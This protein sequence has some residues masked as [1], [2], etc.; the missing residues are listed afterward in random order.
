MGQT[1][2]KTPAY[3]P[4]SVGSHNFPNH[5]SDHADGSRPYPTSASGWIK[6]PRSRFTGGR[7][8]S[9]SST[10]IISYPHHQFI[11]KE[12]RQ[13]SAGPIRSRPEPS[14]YGPRPVPFPPPSSTLQPRELPL[15]DAKL[16]APDLLVASKSAAPSEMAEAKS[17]RRTSAHRVSATPRDPP[18]L[19][20]PE[21]VKDHASA[22]GH[23]E[24]PATP[25]VSDH[26]HAPIPISPSLA[27]A[28]KTGLG[29]GSLRRRPDGELVVDDQQTGRLAT[30]EADQDA[31]ASRPGPQMENAA[32][33]WTHPPR[34]SIP[35][36]W[37]SEWEDL[38]HRP[39]VDTPQSSSFAPADRAQVSRFSFG[40]SDPT[41]TSSGTQS[42]GEL[43]ARTSSW[44]ASPRDS[45]RFSYTASDSGESNQ[46]RNSISVL[47]NPVSDSSRSGPNAQLSL[48]SNEARLALPPAAASAEST[49]R[50]HRHASRTP[51]HERSN[52]SLFSAAAASSDCDPTL[53]RDRRENGDGPLDNVEGQS[54]ARTGPT[55]SAVVHRAFDRYEEPAPNTLAASRRSSMLR[56]VYS[57]A[58]ASGH[59]SLGTKEVEQLRRGPEVKMHEDTIGSIFEDEPA[60]TPRRPRALSLMN[61]LRGMAGKT[62][63]ASIAEA[64]TVTV[65]AQPGAMASN[66]ASMRSRLRSLSSAQAIERNASDKG[67]ASPTR[68]RL[69]SQSQSQS[70]V[71][72]PAPSP[73]PRS[74]SL[75]SA[76]V[77]GQSA[78]QAASQSSQT[79]TSASSQPGG[80]ERKNAALSTGQASSETVHPP[81]SISVRSVRTQRS[82]RSA[83]SFTSSNGSLRARYRTAQPSSVGLSH[84]QAKGGSYLAPTSWWKQN[85]LKRKGS[86]GLVAE[87]QAAKQGRP[88]I[89][90]GG[91]ISDEAGWVDLEPETPASVD[92]T[93]GA[94][95]TPSSDPPATVKTSKSKV[96][97]GL[98]L[99]PRRPSAARMFSFG[100]SRSQSAQAERVEIEPSSPPRTAQT[101]AASAPRSPVNVI[102]MAMDPS[103]GTSRPGMGGPDTGNSSQSSFTS[104]APPVPPAPVP[105]LRRPRRPSQKMHAMQRQDR[106]DSADSNATLS[107]VDV[108][109]GS[110][111]LPSQQPTLTSEASLARSD[112]MRSSIPGTVPS[113]VGTSLAME[114][115]STVAT[116]VSASTQ[117]MHSS[118]SASKETENAL[119]PMSGSREFTLSPAPPM[120]R[121]LSEISDAGTKEILLSD[122]ESLA[123]PEMSP[124]TFIQGPIDEQHP[125]LQTFYPAGTSLTRPVR[126][127]LSAILSPLSPMTEEETGP[128]SP[129]HVGAVPDLSLRPTS[130]SLE[131]SLVSAIAPHGQPHGLIDTSRSFRSVRSFRST[132]DGSVHRY[133]PLPSIPGRSRGWSLDPT[134]DRRD[135]SYV[136]DSFV[137]A[138]AHSQYGSVEQPRDRRIDG[139]PMHDTQLSPLMLMGMVTA[140]SSPTHWTSSS[141]EQPMANIERAGRGPSRSSTGSVT[142]P[143]G[144]PRPLPT[145]PS[146]S[147]DAAVES[148]SAR[149]AGQRIPAVLTA[150]GGEG[151]PLSPSAFYDSKAQTLQL[152]VR[153]P[154]GPRESWNSADG[155]WS[156]AVITSGSM[157]GAVR[158]MAQPER[159]VNDNDVLRHALSQPQE[160]SYRAMEAQP[161]AG[162]EEDEDAE[163]TRLEK[164][165]SGIKSSPPS[166]RV[167]SVE[168]PDSIERAP[169]ADTGVQA[170]LAALRAL[171]S[172]GESLRTILARQRMLGELDASVTE[173]LRESRILDSE[174][175]LDDEEVLAM[176]GPRHRRRAAP[177]PSRRDLYYS[178]EELSSSGRS[179]SG[180]RAEVARRRRRG[181]FT[182]MAEASSASLP[183]TSG[184]GSD[185]EG[186]TLATGRLHRDVPIGRA[187]AH[188][189]RDRRQSVA[190][191]GAVSNVPPAASHLKAWEDLAGIAPMQ[192]EPQAESSQFDR[193]RSSVG[194]SKDI[195]DLAV[196]PP[197]GNGLEEAPLRRPRHDRY[198]TAFSQPEEGPTSVDHGPQHLDGEAGSFHALHRS[199]EPFEEVTL[200]PLAT[201]TSPASTMSPALLLKHERLASQIPSSTAMGG[202]RIVFPSSEGARGSLL[203]KQRTARSPSLPQAF[204]MAG[205]RSSHGFDTPETG[206]VI[207]TGGPSAHQIGR[208]PLAHDRQR[209]RSDFHVS[210]A[211]HSKVGPSRSERR[212]YVASRYDAQLEDLLLLRDKVLRAGSAGGHGRYDS[213]STSFDHAGTASL[214]GDHTHRID[215]AGDRP[216]KSSTSSKRK[217]RSSKLG[218]TMPDIMAWQAGLGASSNVSSR[219]A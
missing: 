85:H 203:S 58:A 14:E 63:E 45:Q 155:P 119:A 36:G 109:T 40:S 92:D 7:R 10:S 39:S 64:N 191:G 172:P 187:S 80:S 8:D 162:L 81:R 124:E 95:K 212:D 33:L 140:A 169:Y 72:S 160:D 83:K 105:P 54:S 20:E 55:L 163:L 16:H 1:P 129:R 199:A 15:T 145:I 18:L 166:Q 111:A 210:S 9:V 197:I 26:G 113:T 153:S 98:W 49:R 89:A 137:T 71:R 182:G 136:A 44:Y 21:S 148:I 151:P 97:G 102:G 115:S 88:G 38:R 79:V 69:R 68:S 164:S 190:G 180:R 158:G 133:R 177:Y 194:R 93:S 66:A 50:E 47:R 146:R 152:P 73:P 214:K 51:S 65:Q 96:A 216:R 120:S 99:W 84:S 59:S 142:S 170:S 173:F 17:I 204:A 207:S 48:T 143:V 37:Q 132:S 107:W 135:A 82:V 202:S 25:S 76:I 117:A 131:G 193:A 67:V 27:L 2:S 219:V 213:H 46:L 57:D 52:A 29:S 206:T 77:A 126:S 215:G 94:V 12:Q 144:G 127:T 24:T 186:A 189:H 121:R 43:G 110:S 205:R 4:S 123:A 86:E 78:S 116:S 208:R 198:V 171:E 114:A 23:R 53:S 42:G 154:G 218:Y 141:H 32:N 185:S 74:Q 104:L 100:M 161:R 175:H 181:N 6:R 178:S 30:E 128:V 22:D 188:T 3:H 112:T 192:T 19:E 134:M 156:A 200:S 56:S 168:L 61:K 179:L 35:E 41:T 28:L 31:L 122:R 34:P 184:R 101:G 157:L 159:S 183:E 5:D 60:P 75:V 62:A 106:S 90:T 108:T 125:D 150:E 174:A 147:I 87:A 209:S 167:E 149:K 91:Q 195:S 70:S 211:R 165:R 11:P 139:L 201:A 118:A 217:S 103:L 13:R 196:T 176:S 130:S 138:D